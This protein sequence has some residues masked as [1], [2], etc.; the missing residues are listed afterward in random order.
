MKISDVRDIVSRERATSP[1]AVVAAHL[2]RGEVDGRRLRVRHKAISLSLACI[3]PIHFRLLDLPILR[4]HQFC[5]Q[6]SPAPIFFFI[7]KESKSKRIRNP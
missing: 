3:V 2:C 1:G 7:S 4:E 6:P 5:N